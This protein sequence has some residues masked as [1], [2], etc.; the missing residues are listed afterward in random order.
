L[1]G[2]VSG[3]QVAAFALASLVLIV[4]P[5]LGVTLLLTGRKD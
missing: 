1:A 3:D 5:G 4:I 2:V